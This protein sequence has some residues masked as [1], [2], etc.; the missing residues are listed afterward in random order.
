MD[1]HD[2]SDIILD[3]DFE[4]AALHLGVEVRAPEFV[5]PRNLVH[6]RESAKD[7]IKASRKG[8]KK[9]IR[10]ENARFVLP[11]LPLGAEDRTHCVLRG[12]FVLCDL[13]PA[14]IRERGVC[15]A[16]HIATLG[17]STQNAE[18]LAELHQSKLVGSVTLLCSL[19]FQQVD[20]T[21]TYREVSAILDGVGRMII[22]RNHAKVICLPTDQGDTFVIE[23]S[24]NLRSSDNLE[25]ITI[26]NDPELLLFHSTWIEQ[27]AEKGETD[28]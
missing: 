16:L 25:Q 3:T 15:P 9:W 14:I 18:S 21:T 12:D 2:L 23:G 13:I 26:F 27:L 17:L 1:S 19:Y 7:K 4:S 10:P 24:A 28:G 8:I 20:K 5:L 22:A 6:R 11:H